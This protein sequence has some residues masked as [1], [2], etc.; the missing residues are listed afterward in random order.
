MDFDEMNNEQQAWVSKQ[1]AL[2]IGYWLVACVAIILGPLLF[3]LYMDWYGYAP[4]VLIGSLWGISLGSRYCRIMVY[5]LFAWVAY[6]IHTVIDGNYMYL[7]SDEFHRG[8]MVAAQSSSE[9]WI[10]LVSIACLIGVETGIKEAKE[11]VEK[12]FRELEV[13]SGSE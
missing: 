9:F 10:L 4:F 11:I 1:Y 8:F 2:H 13:D 12:G 7:L 5:G 6:S 3:C